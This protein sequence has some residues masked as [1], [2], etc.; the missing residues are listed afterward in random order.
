MA[1]MARYA[2]KHFDLAI[3]DPPYYSGPEKREYYGS[4][5]SK[6]GVF[7]SYEKCDTLEIPKE[8]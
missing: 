6:T 1:G 5:N 3:V 7:R 4:R 8:E 2:N